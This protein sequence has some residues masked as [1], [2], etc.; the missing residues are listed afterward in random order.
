MISKVLA[1]RTSA[2]EAIDQ[3]LEGDNSRSAWDMPAE[4]ARKRGWTWARDSISGREYAA[5]VIML[6]MLVKE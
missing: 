4:I 5:L 1:A 3:Y 2:L 6:D